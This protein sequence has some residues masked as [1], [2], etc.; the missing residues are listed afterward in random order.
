MNSVSWDGVHS[1]G[2]GR[3]V[4]DRIRVLGARHHAG[5]ALGPHRETGGPDGGG[6]RGGLI[7]DQVADHPRLGIEDHVAGFFSHRTSRSGRA[8][9]RSELGSAAAKTGVVSRGNTTSAAPWVSCP[10]T[11]LLQDPSTVRSPKDTSGLASWLSEP[12]SAPQGP[13]VGRGVRDVI[14]RDLDL[15][16]DVREVRRGH[17]ESLTHCRGC[18][19]RRYQTGRG[20]R[21]RKGDH[22]GQEFL[23]LT[24][25]DLRGMAL[26]AVDPAQGG[27]SARHEAVTWCQSPRRSPDRSEC[28]FGA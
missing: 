15:F 25:C 21:D 16:Q 2:I 20:Y 11:R 24:H 26:R 22:C 14:F 6:V 13:V 17:R 8:G 1:A 23:C 19:G 4:V 18:R 27:G 5:V 7:D 3:D 10:A 9:S 12:S 28:A